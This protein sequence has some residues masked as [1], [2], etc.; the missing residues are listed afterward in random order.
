[1]A[2]PTIRKGDGYDSKGTG[3]L[4]NDVKTGQGLLLARGFPDENSADPKTAADGFFGSGTETST[5]AFQGSVGLSK[6]G[7]VGEKTWTAL[8]GQ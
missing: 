3:H 6:D 4:N 8:A 7:V 5:K 2:W 1:M